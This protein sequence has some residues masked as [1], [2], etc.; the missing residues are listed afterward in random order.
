M[1]RLKQRRTVAIEVGFE[2][3]GAT[4][5]QMFR[6]HAE[7]LI[8]RVNLPTAREHRESGRPR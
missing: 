1:D 4:R 7:S 6:I 8:L 2:V 3:L 5:V